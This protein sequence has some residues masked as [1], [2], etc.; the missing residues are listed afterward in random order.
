MRDLLLWILGVLTA[1]ALGFVCC[2][3]F[4][5]P[6]A[7][8]C[9]SLLIQLFVAIGTV[10]AVIVAVFSHSVQ[11][12]VFG[13]RYSLYYDPRDVDIN[14]AG[15]RAWF[16][17]TIRDRRSRCFRWLFWPRPATNCRVMLRRIDGPHV[18]ESGWCPSPTPELQ[19]AWPLDK[20]RDSLRQVNIAAG[21]VVRADL[22][23]LRRDI[24]F[25]PV[26]YE[27][28]R[29]FPPGSKWGWVE[30]NKTVRY[31]VYFV[32][33][34]FTTPKDHVFEIYWDG[35]FPATRKDAPEHVRITE[36]APARVP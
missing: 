24:A 36:L 20:E 2:T 8:H 13:P 7:I 32:C 14:D 16:H 30:P 3:L 12:R 28:D 35:E 29:K 23:E 19:L 22:G 1:F 15:D 25:V 31:H 5:K 9:A 21:E 6:D 33:D 27:Y 10:G 34:Q 18:Q 4:E 26:L 17:L 11:F